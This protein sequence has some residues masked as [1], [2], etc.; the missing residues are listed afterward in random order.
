MAVLYCICAVHDANAEVGAIALVSPAQPDSLAS[1]VTFRSVQTSTEADTPRAAFTSAG[2]LFGL[3]TGIDMWIGDRVKIYNLPLEGAVTPS[4]LA[5]LD[6]PLVS[7]ITD[8]YTAGR[9]T[10]TGLGDIVLSLKYRTVVDDL[11]ESYAVVSVKFAS[12]DA[13]AGRG[14]GS[15]EYSFTHKTIFTHDAYRTTL[16]VGVTIPQPTT[17]TIL[18]SS[19]EYA[20]TLAYMA[21]T[22]RR[23]SS[24]GLTFGIKL[25]GLHAFN[26]RV[27][28]ELQ[29]NGVTTL[30]V[31]PEVVWRATDKTALTAGVVMPL[32]TLYDLP[33]A[34]N[35]RDLMVNL[36]V[37]ASF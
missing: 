6:I 33:G 1:T 29:H 2:K 10:E 26:A 5:Q 35:R 18:G 36:R 34:E 9:T 11:F 12:G 21:A 17:I 37:T 3:R 32:L 8:S 7:A 16:M 4:L 14:T 20:P 22:E 27:N 24:T 28:G 31:I 19:V 23:L 15:R 25:A 30:D 13:E